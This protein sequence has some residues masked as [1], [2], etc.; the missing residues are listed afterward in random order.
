MEVA[1]ALTDKSKHE[2]ELTSQIDAF[3]KT[4]R[5]IREDIIRM[6]DDVCDPVP[7]VSGLPPRGSSRDPRIVSDIQT[8]PPHSENT[9]TLNADGVWLS[10]DRS[11]KRSRKKR[12]RRLERA[13]VE[14][15]QPSQQ[16]QLAPRQPK[17]REGTQPPVAAGSDSDEHSTGLQRTVVTASLP[18]KGKSRRAPRTAVVSIKRNDDG[19][20]YAHLLRKARENIALDG[21]G[22]GNTRFRWAANGA[23][24]IEIPGVDKSA[25]ADLLAARLG[26]VLSEDAMSP[27]RL[28][29]V[30]YLYGASMIRSV[31]TK[32]FKPSRTVGVAVRW[33]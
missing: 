32:L 31:P 22:I 30:S 7:G 12:M 6:A 29:M 27:G 26:E 10:A 20:S 2:I 3:V 17:L 5:G 33:T 1:L 14:E 9:E 13:S 8:V 18:S 24:L 28:L 4:R 25:K 11:G 15:K 19:L 23:A 16:Q 21:L